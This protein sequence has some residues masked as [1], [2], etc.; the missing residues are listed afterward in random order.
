[1]TTQPFP[2][3]QG[4]PHHVVLHSHTISQRSQFASFEVGLTGYPGGPVVHTLTGWD[5]VEHLVSC[6][7]AWM[8]V[9]RDIALSRASGTA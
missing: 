4:N 9:G 7:W 8:W 5:A 2:T 1:M 6:G 3:F